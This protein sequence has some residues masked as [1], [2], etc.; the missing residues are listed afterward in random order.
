MLENLKNEYPVMPDEIRDLIEREVNAQMKN[1][2]IEKGKQAK[3]AYWKKAVSAAAA[4]AVILTLG[5][6]VFAGVKLY[7]WN[8]EKEGDYGLRTGVVSED[9]SGERDA[10]ED[11]GAQTGSTAPEEIPV[12]SIEATYLPQGMV[13][14]GDGTEKYYYEETPYRGG[15]SFAV[16]PM[17]E[18]LSGENLPVRDTNVIASETLTLQGKDAV[19]IEKQASEGGGISFNK[20]IYIAYPDYW[21]IVEMYIGEDVTKEEAIEVAEHLKVNSTGETMP[22][23]GQATWGSSQSEESRT[24]DFKFAADADEMQNLHQIGEEFQVEAVGATEESDWEKIDC[25]FA[26]VTDVQV[27]DDFSLLNEACVDSYLKE[28]LDDGGKLVKNKIHYMKSGNGIDTL[29][30]EIR[31]EEVNQKLVYVTVEYTNMGDKELRDV[32][33]F[34]SFIGMEKDGEEYRFYD[35]A[36]CDGDEQ[37]DYAVCDSIGR[38]GEMDYFDVR[39]GETDKNYFSVIPAGGTVTLHLAKVVNE[40]ELDKLYLSLDTSGGAYEFKED[41]LRMGYVDIRQ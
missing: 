4:A 26:K 33:Y 29:D 15:I 9:S 6:T 28:A 38:P 20:K 2:S 10:Q 35:R 17:D 41:A 5:T 22:Y 40:D 8:I 34:G 12:L 1:A 3:G 19:Y 36:E 25:L 30:E 24:V 27:A 32:S 13:A 18:K 37:T 39:G 16:T 31:V 7:Q 23:A 11:A 14:A 21:Q